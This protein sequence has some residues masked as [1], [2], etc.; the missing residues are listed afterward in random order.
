VVEAAAVVVMITAGT[1]ASLANRA[2][3]F[4][5]TCKMRDRP[6]S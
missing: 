5:L 1:H 4:L 6:R 3:S 2:G